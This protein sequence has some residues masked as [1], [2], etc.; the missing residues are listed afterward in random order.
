M[1][2]FRENSEVHGEWDAALEVEIENTENLGG[3]ESSPPHSSPRRGPQLKRK[4]MAAIVAQ[5][6]SL[7][8]LLH[9]NSAQPSGSRKKEPKKRA[10]WSDA[11]L[12]D[13]I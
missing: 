10:A 1:K 7:Q 12:Q 6:P 11:D 9:R 13:A 2:E 5:E 4:R 3:G 8:S